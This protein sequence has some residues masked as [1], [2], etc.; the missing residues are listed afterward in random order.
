MT[1]KIIEVS[2]EK[3]R[4]DS[5]DLLNDYISMMN[6]IVYACSRYSEYREGYRNQIAVDLTVGS[7]ML[8]L[9]AFDV[10]NEFIC[11]DLIDP[12]SDDEEP[13]DRVGR[14]LNYTYGFDWDWM[15]D[16]SSFIGF[17]DLDED[18]GYMLLFFKLVD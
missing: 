14:V 8:G 1:K 12:A 7:Y 4:V 17:Q 6:G 3:V 18:D 15:I 16:P 10:L 2:K 11:A 13:R 5:E 9:D